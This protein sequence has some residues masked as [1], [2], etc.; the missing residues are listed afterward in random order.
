MII[1][2]PSF[3]SLN[4]C[5]WNQDSLSWYIPLIIL[6]QIICNGPGTCIP[7]CVNAYLFKVSATSIFVLPLYKRLFRWNEIPFMIT[8]GAIFL[9]ITVELNLLF[10]FSR[11]TFWISYNG[12]MTS[13]YMLLRDADQNVWFT[14]GVNIHLRSLLLFSKWMNWNG[15]RFMVYVA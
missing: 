14:L 12:Q 3:P 6:I 2:W 5:I 1:R 11:T 9:K 15:V 13:L 8:P 4:Y 10:F 7:I